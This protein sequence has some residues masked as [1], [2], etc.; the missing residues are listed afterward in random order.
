MEWW[1]SEVTILF[2]ELII[3]NGVNA[4]TKDMRLDFQFKS[5]GDSVVN[6]NNKIWISGDDT[7]PWIEAFT[8]SSNGNIPGVFK[9]YTK[10]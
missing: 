1:L 10:Y 7:K 2:M 5:H 4:A 3:L 9:R 6:A 8:L